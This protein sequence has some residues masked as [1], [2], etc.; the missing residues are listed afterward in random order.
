ML[1]G[2]RAD[3]VAQGATHADI[4]FA[5]WTAALLEKLSQI[6]SDTADLQ[7]FCRI[8]AEFL[9]NLRL[10]PARASA[11]A[12]GCGPAM[13]AMPRPARLVSAKRPPKAPR[14]LLPCLE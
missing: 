9:Q 1:Q 11:T 3:Y 8:S 6:T 10:A 4:C 14:L 5:A 12:Q 2:R 13:L 7:N